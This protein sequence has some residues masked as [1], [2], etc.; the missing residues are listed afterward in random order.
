MSDVGLARRVTLVAGVTIAVLAAGAIGSAGSDPP[1]ATSP[2]PSSAQPTASPSGPIELTPQME[3]YPYDPAPPREPTPIDGF[4]LRVFTV[5]RMGGH[6]LGV[7]VHCLR[8]VP[9][10]VDAGTQTLLLYQGRFF[11]EHQINRFRALGN[12]VVRG[13][14]IELFNDVN[15]SRVRGMYR[16]SIKNHQ[17][18]FDLITDPC[19]FE[20]ERSHDL[21][22]APWTK[23]DACHSGIKEWYPALVGC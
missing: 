5:E 9:Y 13:D 6:R 16:W 14:R 10:S 2:T 12:Y 20:D 11:L 18:T 23:V 1:A 3:P 4:Y 7:P 21:T 22:L 15:C 19:P 8:C 17:L